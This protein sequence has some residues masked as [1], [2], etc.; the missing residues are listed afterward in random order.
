MQDARDAGEGIGTGAVIDD[1]WEAV[2][3]EEEDAPDDEGLPPDDIDIELPERDKRDL[4]EAVGGSL[5]PKYE[6]RLANGARAFRSGRYEDARKILAPLADRAPS[7]AA[8]RELYGLTMYRLGRW[9]Q[10]V[11]ELDAF[12]ELSHS[13]E[14]HPV[15]ADC[16]RALKRYKRV[17]ELWDELREVSPSAELVTEGRIVVAGAQA[18]QGDL[19]RALKTLGHPGWKLPRRPK[20]HHLRR[21][22]ALADLYE[23]SGDV[24]RARQ[25]FGRI[26]GAD[27]GF[28]DVKARVRNLA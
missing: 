20:E 17:D 6:Q 22:Y 1:G 2:P 13:T 8:V 21:A 25:L 5:V 26:T 19:K 15:L 27:P 11:R 24:P 12:A 9:K 3:D 23:R 7:S 4:T 16:N 14:Q 28:A 10:A 18:D